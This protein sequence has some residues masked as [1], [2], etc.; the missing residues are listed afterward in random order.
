MIA[1]A[2]EVNRLNI[3]GVNRERCVAQLKK[4]INGLYEQ[5]GQPVPYPLAEPDET[6]G[7]DSIPA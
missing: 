4:Q 7:T 5:L 1:H 3:D 2:E 6:D